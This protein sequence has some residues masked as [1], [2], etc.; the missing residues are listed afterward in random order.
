MDLNQMEYML[1]IAET[2]NLTKAASSLYM[3][4]SALSQQLAKLEKELNVS[5]FI[6]DRHGLIP[7]PAGH[8]YLDGAKRILKIR[9]DT[10]NM[11]SGY[12]SGEEKYIII[13]GASGRSTALFGSIYNDF[14]TAFPD[15]EIRLNESSSYEAERALQQG[16]LNLV[17]T[18][19]LPEELERTLYFSHECL[20]KEKLILVTPRNHPLVPKDYSAS[21]LAD[22]PVIDLALFK[23][24]RFVLPSVR[25]KMRYHIDKTFKEHGFIP[26]IAYDVLGTNYICKSLHNG[27]LC[28]V[29]SSGFLEKNDSIAWF[30]IEDHMSMEYALCWNTSH[31][32]SEAEKF[33]IQLC[34]SKTVQTI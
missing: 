20:R 17:F 29:I 7:T 23:N 26:Q 22:C 33:F 31:H 27:M 25:T 11:L 30:S 1:T 8:V 9:D 18:V 34:K 2:K 4:Q 19:L 14:M 21:C 13:G 6:R 32:L 12:S 16:K 10:L 5:L 15:H 3:T 28:T 24:E